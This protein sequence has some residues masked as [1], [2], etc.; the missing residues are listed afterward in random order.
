MD[1]D[2]TKNGYDL[3]LYRKVS[4]MVKI[5]VIASGGAGNIG[6]MADVLS[7]GGADAVLA[8]SIF[9][10]NEYTVQDIKKELNNKGL[11]VRL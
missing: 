11:Q 5:P 4:E 2:G 8:A 3:Y 7:E 10:F 6:H 9:H 1:F